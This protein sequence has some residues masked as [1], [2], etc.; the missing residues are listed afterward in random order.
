MY[1]RSTSRV[2]PDRTRWIRIRTLLAVTA[3]VIVVGSLGVG[4]LTSATDSGVTTAAPPVGL[5][6]LSGTYG[7]VPGL[8]H[9]ESP[10]AA[11]VALNF[12]IGL[13]LRNTTAAQEYLNTLLTPGSPSFER[14]IPARQF[15]GLFGPT[16]GSVQGFMSSLRSYGLQVEEADELGLIL[17]VRGPAGDVDRAFHTTLWTFREGPET[18]VAPISTPSLPSSWAGLVG[19][20]YGLNGFDQPTPEYTVVPSS[21]PQE[22]TPPEMESAYNETGLLSSGKNGSTNVIGLAEECDST[23]TDAQYY[24]DANTSDLVY[25]LAPSHL[26]FMLNTSTDCSQSG[27]GLETDLDIQ[28]AHAMAPGADEVVCLA[29]EIP[30]ICDSDFVADGIP[31]GSDSWNDGTTA[32]HAVWMAAAAAGITL[33]SGAGDD[34]A[35]TVHEPG[36]DPNGVGVGGTTL[37]LNGTGYGGESA[38]NCTDGSGTGGGC[39]TADAPPVYQVGMWGYPG[40]CGSTTVRGAPDVGMDA[41]PDSGF[42]VE[43]P[44]GTIEVG[45]NSLATPLWA[46]TLATIEGAA[47]THDF[48]GPVLYAVGKDPVAYN[49]SFHQV[50]SGN[51]GYAATAGWDPLTGIGSPNIGAL[52]GYWANASEGALPLS[53]RIAADPSRLDVNQTTIL[54]GSAY[55]GSGDYSYQWSQLPSGCASVNAAQLVCTPK[56]AYNGSVNLTVT[57][58][59][60]RSASGYVSLQVFG[61]IVPGA[62]QVSPDQIDAGMSFVATETASGGDPP[63]RY[64]WSVTPSGECSPVNSAQVSCTVAGAGSYGISVNVTDEQGEVAESGASPL[65]VNP[66]PLASL[67][68][69]PG[70]FEVGQSL[71]FDAVVHG[72]TGPFSYLWDWN[73]AEVPGSNSSNFSRTA[74][75]PGTYSVSFVA[76]DRFGEA[77]SSN[78]DQ[79]TVVAR[80]SVTQVSAVPAVVATGAIVDLSASVSGGLA[81]FND[82]WSDL[83]PGCS[84]VDAPVLACA[85]SA[86]GVFA[87]GFTVTDALGVRGVGNV[88][89]TVTSA[90]TTSGQAG[91]PGPLGDLAVYA[92]IG[93]VAAAAVVLSIVILRRRRRPPSPGQGGPESPS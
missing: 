10:V 70:P 18:E 44:S 51:N 38:W 87:I 23:E 63:F 66:L 31:F 24:A 8:A 7:A 25:G 30:Y 50:T 80:P 22:V 62:P 17:S 77:A 11:S 60:G 83:P 20:L 79:F 75:Q 54:N 45:G 67:A 64:N 42:P 49:A 21:S 9:A 85:P 47:G 39:D 84:S 4:A 59:Q 41:D 1:S 48:A 36:D 6:L 89:V 5:V 19:A 33:L 43:T 90:S 28:A 14:Y 35:T 74:P 46:G 37:L 57:D 2:R 61:A 71:N 52:E 13:N 68:A 73:G 65:L 72:G 40:V 81:P 88:T 29:D 92:A 12:E 34:C 56:G 82:S 53:A 91:A 27:W 3:A 55:G 32:D 86:P 16:P 58:G 69:E 93:G 15:V 76:T 78:A 26:S